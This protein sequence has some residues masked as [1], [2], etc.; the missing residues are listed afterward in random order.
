[1]RIPSNLKLFGRTITIEYDPAL[2]HNDGVHGWAKYRQDVITLQP[3]T[4]SAPITREQM[5]HHYLHE[6]MYHILY[7]AGED[8]FDPPLHERECLVDRI[9]GL[10]HQALTTAEY[11]AKSAP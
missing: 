3:C 6:L 1:M 10:L 9:A 8:Q 4:D 2:Q 11:G 5:E 7:A